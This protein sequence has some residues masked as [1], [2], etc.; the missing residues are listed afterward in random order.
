MPI[1]ADLI[2]FSPLTIHYAYFILTP[3]V[4]SIIFYTAPTQ[5]DS[6]H[7]VDALFMCFSAMTGTG[8][9]VLDLSTLGSLQQATLFSLLILGHAFPVFAFISF[10]RAISFRTALNDASAEEKGDQTVSQIPISQ[11]EEQIGCYKEDPLPAKLIDK[12]KV[13][14]AVRE[15]QADI[16]LWNAHELCAATELRHPDEP[17]RGSSVSVN[18]K[19]KDI[20]Y[21]KAHIQ[22]LISWFKGAVNRSANHLSC[23]DSICCNAPGGIKYMALCLITGIVIMYF[24]GFLILG[25]VSIGLWSKFVRPDI[26]R[27]DKVSPFWAGAFLATSALCN[28]GMSLIDTN[29]GPYQ[30]EPF[31]LLACGFLILAGNAL[32]P[33]LLRF[34]IWVLRTMLPNNQTWQLWRRTFD[35]TLSQPH[36]VCAYLY[37]TW[38]TWFVLGTIIF[39]NALMWGA[40]EI[41]AIHNEEIGSLPIKF[42]VLDG[43]FQA[44]ESRAWWWVLCCRI[45]SLATGYISAFPVSAAISSTEVADD[46]PAEQPQQESSRPRFSSF[47]HGRFVYKQLRS[48]FSHDIWWLSLAILLITIVESDHFTAEPLA[49]ST[50]KII[51]EAVSAYSCVGVTIG[52]PGKSYAFCGAWHTLSKLLLIAVSLRGRHRGLSVIVNADPSLQPRGVN[53]RETTQPEKDRHVNINETSL[54]CV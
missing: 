17:Q 41:S 50:F 2:R 38:H 10:L 45:R 3:T 48:Q 15:V 51:F 28:N 47:P 23:R 18:H 35:F 40:F 22:S 1:M 36:K 20:G 12:A 14:M 19:K 44:L 4:C 16:G 30:K 25:I 13:R 34:F 11:L 52:Y 46:W 54:G 32:F 6:L 31:P 42:R 39:L 29:M 21:W 27:E 8:L 53:G 7:Y 33:C 37:P 5:I 43:L 26:P 49:F 24:I 9:N